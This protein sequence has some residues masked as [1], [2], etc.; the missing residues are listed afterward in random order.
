M[1]ARQY[2]EIVAWQLSNSLKQ[3]IYVRTSLGPASR[4]FRFCDQIRGACSS[5]PANIAE[6]FCRFT[7]R[8]FAR[9]LTIARGSL[10]ETQNHLED[11]R[12]RGYFSQT[13]FDELWNLSTRAM[14]ATTKLLL[15]LRRH[16]DP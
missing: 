8:E 5:V 14:A 16:P 7:H 10:G 12:D 9:F 6:G 2:R 15:Y 1:G 4:D 11:G 13:D 3:A